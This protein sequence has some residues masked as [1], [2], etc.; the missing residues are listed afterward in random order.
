MM[1]RLSLYPLPMISAQIF[2]MLLTQPADHSRVSYP[3]A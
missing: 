2:F 3:S 1:K